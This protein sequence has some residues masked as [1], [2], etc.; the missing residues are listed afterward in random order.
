[1]LNVPDF[2]QNRYFTCS[3]VC[4]RM[5]LAYWKYEADE[6]SLSIQCG[7]TV[8]G[9]AAKQVVAA[10]QHLGF[11]GEYQFHCNYSFLRRT[12]QKGVPP[13][14]S[15]DPNLLYEQLQRIY[16][17]H[18]IVVLEI[19]KNNIVIHDPDVGTNLRVDPAIFKK[20]WSA[21]QN[22]V[23]LVWPKSKAFTL[24]SKK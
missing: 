7:T 12:L 4:L 5:V 6:V 24:K 16:A 19:T 17:R 11:Q 14:V 9:T 21:S 20:S 18:V 15:I 1:M 2:K 22:E 3:P 13:I 10:A 23:I 8:F